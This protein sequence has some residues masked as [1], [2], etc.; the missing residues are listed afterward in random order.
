M[1]STK[2]AIRYSK[3]LLELAVEQNKVDL[4]LKDMDFFF[5]SSRDN[6]DLL[7]F[8]KSPVIRADK[9]LNVLNELFSHFNVL[10]T[11]FIQL[12]VKNGRESLLPEIAASFITL[13]KDHKGIVP[14]T[15]IS[16]TT[17]SKESKDKILSKIKI[18][19]QIELTELIDEK[20]IGGFVVRIG[21]IQ[22]DASVNNQLKK[23]KLD[24]ITNN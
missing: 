3:A 4:I 6:N 21:D 24:L 1:K 11:S 22:I 13:V 10:T 20:L 17:L 19:G 7:V 5:H 23:L 12:I 18:S 2:S 15:L 16:A 8:L 9:K 14:L